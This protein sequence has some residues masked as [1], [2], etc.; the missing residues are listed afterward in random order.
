MIKKNLMLFPILFIALIFTACSDSEL[1]ADTT[2]PEEDKVA[3]EA[4]VRGMYEWHFTGDLSPDFPPT[5]EGAKYTNIDGD[6]YELTVSELTKSG[7]FSANFIANHAALANS[8]GDQLVSG[9]MEWTVGDLPPFGNGA[10]A[11]CDCQDYP[12][13]FWEN[14]VISIAE[15]VQDADSKSVTWKFDKDD[16]SGYSLGVVK[17]DGAWK[18]DSMQAFDAAT[19]LGE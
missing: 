4:V 17:Q 12:D 13:N 11:W 18:I 6:V 1:D 7:Y 16:D 8:I 2:T 9:K 14:M 5:E 10:N 15:S 19:F 3:I